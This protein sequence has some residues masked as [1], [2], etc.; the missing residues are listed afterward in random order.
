MQMTK[1][2][3]T[4]MLRATAGALL[5]TSAAGAGAGEVKTWRRQT[6]KDFAAGT[7]SRVMV[8]SLGQVRLSPVI[9]PLADPKATHVWTTAAGADGVAYFATGTPGS[10]QK[11][12]ATGEIAELYK[13]E[14][15]QIFA[16]A[17]A[18]NEVI[19]GVSPTG[20][21]VAISPDGNSRVLFQTM[22]TY[23]WA[24]AV[25]AQGNI[26]AATGPNGKLF[27][28]DAQGNGDVLF[29]AKQPHLLSMVVDESGVLF[30]GT[31]R[32]G[33]V[34]R[35]TPDGRP[36]VLLDASQSD[37]QTLL[38]AEDGAVFAGTGTPERPKLS[39]S[40]NDRSGSSVRSSTVTSNTNNSADG[41]QTVATTPST[42][43]SSSSS[44]TSTS[45]ANRS[46]SSSAGSNA[47]YRIAPDGSVRQV[48]EEKTLVLSLAIQNNRLIV[49]T[50]Q[51]GRLYEV[52]LESQEYG[53]LARLEH[54]QINTLL[55]QKDGKI[56]LGTGTPGK[57]YT[58]DQKLSKEGTLLSD[59]L[60][61]SMQ[62]RW[63]KTVYQADVPD[64]T[65]LILEVRTGNVAEPDETWTPW[66]KPAEDLPVARFY[67]YRATLKS[68][69]GERSPVLR[70][71][72]VH[73]ATVNQPPSIESIEV[74]DVE[75]TPVEKADAKLKFK[76]QASDPNKDKL[77]Y[78]VEVRKEGWPAWVTLAEDLDK[79]EYEWD[80]GS[81]PGGTYQARISASDEGSN[82]GDES[83][84][85][86]RT[87]SSFIVD[88]EPP[89]VS[90]PEVA[91][92]DGKLS[93]KC[94]ANDS[95][96]RLTAAGY[97]LDGGDWKELFPDDG[98]FD[99]NAESV[100][101]ETDKLGPGG[102]VLLVRFRDAAGNYG[103]TDKLVETP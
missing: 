7:L 63:G 6:Q 16:V 1:T 24:L 48:F 32:D 27:K 8:D 37:I 22:E 103:V 92:N 36:Y 83:H 82:R 102:H 35:V 26:F 54:G 70:S 94:K 61:T 28:I 29:K 21:V 55:P 88:R 40:S 62:T 23:I 10:V 50:G 11:V 100:T 71:V 2:M 72:A 18:N 84:T 4:W 78:K 81:L 9:E 80:P 93:V 79:T 86:Q 101:F 65:S 75:A 99:S 68:D 89:Q 46:S 53:E 87:S 25:D 49:G 38:L 3:R 19:A 90:A 98:I 59:V 41:G 44:T 74:P 17:V 96:T 12:A 33:I 64:H 14:N 42:P 43:P 85:V 5:L 69:S 57:I 51:E 56:V 13:A 91:V 39:G 45:R 97:S 31:D 20:E 52:D 60:D 76:W 73:Y 30:V 47:V 34:Y 15:H 66:K 77:A 67:Q 58:L 95:Q